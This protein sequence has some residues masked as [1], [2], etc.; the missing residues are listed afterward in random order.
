MPLPTKNWIDGRAALL[1]FV[2]G[3]AAA[4]P[5]AVTNATRRD[6][7]FFDV[8]LTSDTPGLTQF[9]WDLGQKMN[10]HDSSVQP[11]RIEAKPVVYRFIVPPGKFHNF[12]FDP[13]NYSGRLTLS[14]ARIV[15][16]RGRLFH[17]FKPGDFKAVQQIR[18]LAPQ[19]ETVICETTADAGDPFY[20]LPLAEPLCLPIQGSMWL[21]IVPL[22]ALPVFFFGLLL[23]S[24]WVLERLHKCGAPP[25]RWR[26]AAPLAAMARWTGRHPV[27]AL[28]AAAAVGVAVQCHPVIFFSRSFV[29]PDNASYL[30]YDTFPTLPGY[31]TTELEDARGADVAAILLQHLYYPVESYRAIF[32]DGELPLWNRYDLGGVPLLGQG[33]TMFGELLNFLPLFAR[34]A[35]WAWDA[36]FILAHWLYGFGI[37]LVV[38]RLTRH[39]GVAALVAAVAGYV[40]FFAFRINHPAQFSVCLSPWILVAWLW[41]GEARTRKSLVVG[42][43]A[44]IFANWEVMNSGTIKEAYM[45]MVCLNVAGFLLILFDGELPWAD[46]GRKLR[47]T[48]AAGVIF[49]LLSAPVWLI[50]LDALAAS[51]TSYNTPGAM[52]VPWWQFLG[53]FEDLFY[54]QLRT[55]EAHAN[56]SANVLILVAVAWLLVR[57]QESLRDGRVRGLV[58]A[59][60]L[61]LAIVFGF[62]PASLLVKIP[63][64]ANIHHTDNTF[65]CSLIVLATVL[66]GPGLLCLI[67][68]LAGHAWLRPAALVAAGLGLLLWAYFAHAGS[69]TYSPFFRGYIPTLGLALV[70]GLAGLAFAART[71]HA[72]MRVAAVAGTLFLLL[73]RHGEYL[74]TPFDT[75][76]FNPKIRVDF[77]NPSAAVADVQARMT[78]PS[79]PAGIGFNLFSGYHQMLGWEGI[80]GVDAL[81]NGWYDDLAIAGGATKVRWWDHP[82]ETWQEKDLTGQLPLQDLLNVRYYL[83][84]HADPAREI[85]GLRFLSQHDLD[86][87]ESPTAWPRAFFTDQLTSHLDLPD[88]VRQL[89][90]GDRRP[91]ASVSRVDAPAG[92]R[93][94]GSGPALAN[95]IV[96]PAENYRLTSNTTTF[97]ISASGPGVAVLTESY[98]PQDFQAR[99]D[100]EPVPYFRVN[101][102]FKGIRIPAAGTFEVSFTYRPHHLGLA[103]ALA[104][105]GAALALAGAVW[106]FRTERR[107]AGDTAVV[108]A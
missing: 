36:K 104:A 27:A 82:A 58:L 98:Y 90:G 46:R 31:V 105:A 65:S 17:A 5:L 85:A 29:S 53:F 88:F 99:L 3:I 20:D 97:R 34:S 30:L 69:A 100:G 92:S 107:F 22:L 84:T 60:L 72:G 2:L 7:Y 81:R 77:T 32:E 44:W 19:G 28:A 48:A 38:F 11:L 83:A 15:D 61:P 76:V 39:R 56:P 75:Y 63:F 106:G 24:P 67:R 23:S 8:T 55:G 91:F 16:Y 66:S 93:L 70:L 45:L 73:W 102:A 4:L 86:V 52:Q 71:G 49:L 37:G 13:I 78:E 12:R 80:Y 79:R 40:G 6:F 33:Q 18:Q 68:D 50:F 89:R 26:S 95:R 21:R 41:I 47:A 14:H 9:F 103:L 43:G 57:G 35:T 10:E 94:T 74:A 101:H 25:A 59:S 51:Q 62:I 108:Q 54:R 96:R 1:A 64:I 87:Y 42:L